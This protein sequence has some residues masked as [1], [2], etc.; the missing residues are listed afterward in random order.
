MNFSN[1]DSM[2][3]GPK[4]SDKKEVERIQQ[5]LAE[6]IESLLNQ[7]DL[8]SHAWMHYWRNA[9][10]KLTKA[11]I[12]AV[13]WSTYWSSDNFDRSL[14]SLL[15][16]IKT[17][18][19][20]R[21][22]GLKNSWTEGG[23]GDDRRSHLALLQRLLIAVECPCSTPPEDFRHQR[24]AQ[25]RWKGFFDGFNSELSIQYRLG[26]FTSMEFFLPSIFSIIR[27]GVIQQ[28]EGIENL[29]IEGTDDFEGGPALQFLLDHE[30]LDGSEDGHG[31]EALHAGSFLCQSEDEYQQQINIEMFLA[32]AETMLIQ[33]KI[34]FDYYANGGIHKETAFY[35]SELSRLG[36]A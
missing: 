14:L 31:D 24:V 4:L 10:N 20:S 34:L 35:Q 8:P 27:Q 15:S 2:L 19:K 28:F 11:N 30:E 26:S 16:E 25:L 29:Y 13:F 32:G 7:Y 5:Q 23:A 18:R 36:L 1:S 33:M 17:V 12:Q 6:G 21:N 22:L 9:R 3:T